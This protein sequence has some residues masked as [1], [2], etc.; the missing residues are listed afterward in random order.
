MEKVKEILPPKSRRIIE[1]NGFWEEKEEQLLL[2]SVNKRDCV[3][4]VYENDIAKCAL[5][6]LY[7]QEEIDFQKPFK[8]AT[9]TIK[10]HFGPN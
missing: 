2:R 1:E 5:E 9:K 8:N 10:N 6:K 4:V 3:F 7:F